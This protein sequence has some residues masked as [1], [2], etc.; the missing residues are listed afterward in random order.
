M[1]ETSTNRYPDDTGETGG[2]SPFASESSVGSPFADRKPS[3]LH[4][5]ILAACVA[6]YMSAQQTIS[7]SDSGASAPEGAETLLWGSWAI[8]EGGYLAGLLLLVVRRVRGQKF[9]RTG[10]EIL[11]VIGGIGV[12]QDLLLR[13]VLMLSENGYM[14]CRLLALLLGLV[15][16]V[17][18]Y[19][20]AVRRCRGRWRAYYILGAAVA[21]GWFLVDHCLG[22]FGHTGYH[23]AYCGRMGIF[24]LALTAVA[25]FDLRS[26]QDR[27][28]WPHWFGVGLEV[29]HLVLGI[30]WSLAM[31]VAFR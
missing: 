16:W 31:L 14:A 5:M 13:L 23:V 7:L 25:A 8:L 1:S 12:A 19:L 26:T 28:S 6:V 24:L 4:L 21:F 9:P 17:P 2:D 10:G 22:G 27:F 3:V 20:Y 18:V 15:V 11:W 29:C 30:G